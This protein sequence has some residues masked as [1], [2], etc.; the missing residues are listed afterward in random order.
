MPIEIRHTLFS[1]T[2]VV[3]ALRLY[4]QQ[5]GNPFPP[6]TLKSF[7][8]DTD[9]DIEVVIDMVLDKLGRPYRCMYDREEQR[10]AFI[11]YFLENRIPM[12]A[13]G[14]EKT[15]EIFDGQLAFV[16]TIKPGS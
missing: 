16:I 15:V 7:T 9:D 5:L 13:T 3:D 6:A 12:P 4:Q 8:L 14:A 10:E 1:E 11:V 2:E